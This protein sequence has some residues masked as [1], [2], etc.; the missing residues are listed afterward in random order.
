M[1]SGVDY[2]WT[3]WVKYSSLVDLSAYSGKTIQVAFVHELL[4]SEVGGGNCIRIDNIL[5]EQYDALLTPTIELS[6][7]SYTFPPVGWTTIDG[8]Y[9]GWSSYGYGGNSGS[10]CAVV[11]FSDMAILTTPRLDLTDGDN[12][13]EFYFADVYDDE[14]Y[15]GTVPY[16]QFVVELSSDGGVTWT[17]SLFELTYYNNVFEKV[18][19]TLDAYGDNC[20]IRFT[21]FIEGLE[22]VTSY[23]D[24]PTYSV[25]YL[26]DVVL[27]KL[28]GAN[29]APSAA[30]VLTPANGA[31][32]VYNKLLNLSWNKALFATDYKLY[33]GSSA[34]SFDLVDGLSV[35]DVASYTIETVLPYATTY[36]WKVVPTNSAG[37]ATDVPV[38]SFTTVEDKSVKVL[39]HFE[40]FEDG[41]IPLGWN[42]TVDGYT[43][44]DIANWGAFDGSC[45]A[46]ASGSTVGSS[47]TLTTTEVTLPD[48]A[49]ISFYWGNSAPIGL[50]VDN[51]GAAKNP[52]TAPNDYDCTYF[53]IEV[54]GVWTTLAMLSNNDEDYQYWFRER[55]SLT[56]YAGKVVSFRWRYEIYNYMSNY[57]ALD[58]ILIETIYLAETIGLDANTSIT[59]I[60][61]PYYASSTSGSD[62]PTSVEVWMENTTDTGWD[63]MI[64]FTDTLTTL[65]DAKVFSGTITWLAAGSSSNYQ[66]ATCKFAEPFQYTG[67]NIRVLIKSQTTSYKQY[68]F[69][70]DSDSS[71]S[72]LY[73][74]T[75]GTLADATIYEKTSAQP[76]VYFGTALTPKAIAGTVTDVDGD[77]IA[78]ATVTATSGDVMYAAITDEDGAYSLEV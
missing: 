75:D 19:M 25:T 60:A 44:W 76:V 68:Y 43:D 46:M 72:V 74:Y 38:W 56:E 78:G 8:I 36:Y 48:S 41:I 27:P 64:A 29:D 28:Y 49:Q 13:F 30:T 7:S 61:Y 1:D 69:G 9:G 57:V 5:V 23:D 10:K 21:Y 2:P 14:D 24:M 52:T 77:A 40:G 15:E 6:V 50:T 42:S 35:G 34:T 17:E 31:K 26:D 66:I 37:E 11:S 70:V 4:V 67:G 51:T 53:E 59:E 62:F 32:D 20:Y 58:N 54:D 45:S 71:M 73:K 18:S 55:H 65:V 47:A 33:V 22:S 12:Y 3:G 39:P 16:S 63:D